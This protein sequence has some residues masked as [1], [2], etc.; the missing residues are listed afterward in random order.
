MLFHKLIWRFDPVIHKR[1]TSESEQKLTSCIYHKKPSVSEII[2]Y[3]FHN[4]RINQLGKLLDYLLGKSRFMTFL[5]F[6]LKIVVWKIAGGTEAC[7]RQL[8][9]ERS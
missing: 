4:S 7:E 3:R 9:K 8:G 5:D 6:F 1:L 2:E